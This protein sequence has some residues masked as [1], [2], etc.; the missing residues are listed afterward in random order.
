MFQRNLIRIKVLRSEAIAWNHR[1]RMASRVMEVWYRLLMLM[2][3]C[4]IANRFRRAL[5]SSKSKCTLKNWTAYKEHNKPCWTR[6]LL[7]QRSTWRL[8]FL[9]HSFRWTW[10][11]QCSRF[12][13][14]TTCMDLTITRK[15]EP[16]TKSS[17]R[18]R[19]SLRRKTCSNHRLA[20]SLWTSIVVTMDN[21]RAPKADH[22][23]SRRS[24]LR[25]QS[26]SSL[27]DVVDMR[28]TKPTQRKDLMWTSRSTTPALESR[29]KLR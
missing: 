9:A 15:V 25:I 17:L 11:I 22:R 21:C 1:R 3:I 2:K 6:Q 26:G 18:Q 23:A 24:M 12:H 4:S 16:Q 8:D 28:R 10:Q 13:R 27:L 19:P 29:L 7:I 20:S 5:K 14:Y